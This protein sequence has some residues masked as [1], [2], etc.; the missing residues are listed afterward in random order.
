MT[1]NKELKL[2]INSFNL[3]IHFRK[4]ANVCNKS[5]DMKN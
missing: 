3:V 2:L 4:P 5:A 1:A